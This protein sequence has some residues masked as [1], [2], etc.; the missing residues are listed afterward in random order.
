MFAFP[1]VF[2]AF[3]VLLSYF[4]VF[5]PQRASG[6]SAT[7]QAFPSSAISEFYSPYRRRDLPPFHQSAW[8][9]DSVGHV[10]SL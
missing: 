3:F 10:H 6:A 1:P 8:L 7:I 4:L 5:L 2:S 9:I